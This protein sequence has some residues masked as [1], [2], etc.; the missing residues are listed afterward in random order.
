MQKKIKTTIVLLVSVFASIHSLSGSAHIISR[1]KSYAS[2]FN[3]AEASALLTNSRKW[4][5]AETILG[6]LGLLCMGIPA[7]YKWQTE[8][9]FNQYGRLINAKMTLESTENPD[10]QKIKELNFLIKSKVENHLYFQKKGQSTR[11]LKLPGIFLT[12][13]GICEGIGKYFRK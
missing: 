8:R 1:F 7:Y 11:F 2:H 10:Q 4:I 6:G 5:T 3:K 9:Y 13:A 12:L